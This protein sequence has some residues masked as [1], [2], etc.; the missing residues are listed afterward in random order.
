MRQARRNLDNG[1]LE[2]AQVRNLFGQLKA[3]F[4]GPTIK[5]KPEPKTKL[6]Y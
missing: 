5:T 1:S 2:R 6:C 3:F 4:F